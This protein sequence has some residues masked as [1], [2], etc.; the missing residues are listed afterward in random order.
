MA[1]YLANTLK[2]KLYTVWTVNEVVSQNIGAS[3]DY[4]LPRTSLTVR[5]AQVIGMKMLVL[6]FHL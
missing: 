1:D 3:E 4:F 2:S 6:Q 5:N